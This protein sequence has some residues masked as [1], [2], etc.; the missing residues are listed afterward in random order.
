MHRKEQAE[1]RVWARRNFILRQQRAVRSTADGK[2]FIVAGCGV[3]PLYQN[4]STE[5]ERGY[6]HGFNSH[7]GVGAVVGLADTVE[8]DKL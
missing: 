8:Q 3:A 6:A 4:G 5:G 1:R 2:W 7:G